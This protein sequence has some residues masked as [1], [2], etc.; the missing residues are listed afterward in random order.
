MNINENEVE[1]GAIERPSPT[2]LP[3]TDMPDLQRSE[4]RA[5]LNTLQLESKLSLVKSWVAMG[6][7]AMK[8]LKKRM[9]KGTNR[10]AK[11]V[12]NAFLANLQKA[13]LEID[14]VHN[15]IVQTEITIFQLRR[16][17]SCLRKVLHQKLALQPLPPANEA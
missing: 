15:L 2:A 11:A 6:L 17:L 9:D 12:V 7:D 3:P 16:E 1:P 8:D 4:Q 10:E 5:K 14:N 13:K